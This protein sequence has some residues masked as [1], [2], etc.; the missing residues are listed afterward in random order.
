MPVSEGISFTLNSVID[1]EDQA[2]A[3]RVLGRMME[4]P[5]PRE[6]K[7]YGLFEPVDQRIVFR[8][9]DPLIGLWLNR[10]TPDNPT[11]RREGG[12]LLRSASAA[13]YQ[14]SWQKD[15]QPSFSFVGG[16]VGGSVVR[17]NPEVL[18]DLLSLVKDLVSE[19]RPVYGE[20]RNPA[21]T[22][23]DLPFNLQKR[24]PDIPWISIYGPA[25]VNLF[26]TDAVRSAPFRR[27]VDLPN[28]YVWA[29]VTESPF[30]AVTPQVKEQIRKHLG[31]D[32]FMSHGRWRYTD[33]RA[34]TF[35]FSAVLLPAARSAQAT[36][37]PSKRR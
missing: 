8:N 36:S 27:V 1:F 9:I 6:P 14:I 22:G 16:D 12:L 2:L 13:G 24:L 37:K 30:D 31:E 33:G 23:W 20:V 4:A 19:V 5:G 28:D 18:D 10:G 17:S 32:A 35:D 7:R 21:I 11:D 26:G 3:R 25:Y 29:Q 34:P 15:S